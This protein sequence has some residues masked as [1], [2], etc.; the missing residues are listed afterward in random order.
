MGHGLS[1]FQGRQEPIS[2]GLTVTVLATDIL[3]TGGITFFGSGELE[4]LRI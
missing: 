2:E 4:S 3:K 1:C